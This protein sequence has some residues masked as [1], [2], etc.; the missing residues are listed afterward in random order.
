MHLQKAMRAGC[1]LAWLALPSLGITIHATRV[2]DGRGAVLEN[3]RITVEDTRIVGVE[4][5]HKGSADYNLQ[6]V[7]LMPG[8]I[9]THVHIGWHFNKQDRAD[10]AKDEMQ[11]L[12]VSFPDPG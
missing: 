3:V 6:E 10:T 8:W 12:V 7:T 1:L 11:S 9:D 5:G 4:P 2:L